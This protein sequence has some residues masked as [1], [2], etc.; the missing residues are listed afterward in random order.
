[1]ISKPASAALDNYPRRVLEN[2]SS[3]ILVLDAELHLRF[4]NVAAEILLEVS[5][6]QA[7]NTPFGHL[8]GGCEHMLPGL[9]RCLRDGHAYT[10][11]EVQL[12]TNIGHP[13]TVDFTVTALQEDGPPGELLLEL[14]HIDRRLR[15]AREEELIVQY[16]TARALIRGLAHEVK[17][18]LGGLRGAAQLLEQELQ[19]PELHEYTSVIIRE[20][21]RLRNLLDRM[22]GPCSLPRRQPVNIHEVLERVATLLRAEAGERLQLTRVYDPSIPTLQADRDQLIQALLNI[23][24]NALQAAEGVCRVEIRTRVDRQCTLGNRRHRL[25]ACV[26]ITDDGPGIPAGMLQ[27]I[28]YPM[29][30]GRTDGT[31]LGLS[32]AQNL[33][34]QHDGLIECRSAPGE[35]VFTVLLPLENTDER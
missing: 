12:R 10:E 5:T 4:M 34:N 25:V 32:I 23:G 9:R 18:P 35:T 13:I 17:N 8:L 24:R 21:D 7:L 26:D 20:A 15:I 2:M 22:L 30:T 33:I 3:A 27:Q 14:R 29:I 28:F 16:K 6:R 31:G 19:D 11:R 1:M